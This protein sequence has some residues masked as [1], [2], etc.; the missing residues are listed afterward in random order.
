MLTCAAHAALP[1][2]H[3]CAIICCSLVA[4]ALQQQHQVSAGVKC[5]GEMSACSGRLWRMP[6]VSAN[7]SAGLLACPMKWLLHFELPQQHWVDYE[8][9]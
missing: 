2:S 6:A 1:C 4:R 3:A 8:S 5:R 9:I 7:S